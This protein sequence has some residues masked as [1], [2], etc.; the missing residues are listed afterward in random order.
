VFETSQLDVIVRFHDVRRLSE[1]ERCVFSLVGQSY[2]PLHIILVLQRFSTD[3]VKAMRTALAP[4]F[5]IE[6]APHISVLN[7]EQAQPVDARA[8]LLAHG[9]KN[10][11][12]RYVAFLDYDDVLYPEAYKLMVARLQESGAAIAFA[13]VRVMVVEP[14]DQ[15]FYVTREIVPPPFS[16]S[17]LIDLF[18]HNFCPI[19]SYVMDRSQLP[20]DVLS[21]EVT[22]T[23]EEDYDLLLRICA[24]V[25]SD[26]SMVGTQIGDYCYK[27]D[28]SNTIRIDGLTGSQLEYYEQVVIPAI[29]QRRQTTR[30]SAIVRQTLGLH[31]Q[32]DNLTIRDV[33]RLTGQ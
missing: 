10:A 17:N 21:D 2:R 30:V 3:H 33:L 13:T 22:F 9:L 27:A 15:F 26:F 32:G 29:E 5:E 6:N 11:R 4:L 25:Q 24:R 19:H 16:G 14:Y 7:W 8:L 23:L 12:G 1:L 20:D 31:D 18:R 28:G